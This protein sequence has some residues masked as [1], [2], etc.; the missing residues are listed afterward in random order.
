MRFPCPSTDASDSPGALPEKLP[1]FQ[2]DNTFAA[3][4]EVCVRIIAQEVRGITT[5]GSRVN[6]QQR[7]SGQGTLAQYHFEQQKRQ[8][9]RRQHHQRRQIQKLQKQKGVLQT[10]HANVQVVNG[11]VDEQHLQPSSKQQDPPQH[12]HQRQWE[13]CTSGT[14]TGRSPH[15]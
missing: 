12:Q 8:Q 6:L 5:S 3:L 9:R 15:L 4:V 2:D 7:Q 13:S 10:R 11:Q 14:L 1:R